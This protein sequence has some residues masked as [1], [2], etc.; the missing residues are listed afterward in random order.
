MVVESFS[1]WISR[2]KDVRSKKCTRRST[3]HASRHTRS[4]KIARMSC[5]STGKMGSTGRS[6]ESKLSSQTTGRTEERNTAALAARRSGYQTSGSVALLGVA[7]PSGHVPQTKAHRCIRALRAPND[8]DH[9]Q[10]ELKWQRQGSETA[11]CREKSLWQGGSSAWSSRG[12]TF[13]LQPVSREPAR[14]QGLLHRGFSFMFQNFSFSFLL[15]LVM[16]LFQLFLFFGAAHQPYCLFCFWLTSSLP[17]P[18]QAA[19]G[20]L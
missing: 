4:W 9:D 5:S 6:C 8:G 16:W 15:S 10:Q 17:S 3:R 2:W 14:G 1:N 20:L 18:A 11:K 7:L 19:Q 12:Q 13:L